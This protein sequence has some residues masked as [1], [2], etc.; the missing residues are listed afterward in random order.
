MESSVRDD[1]RTVDWVEDRAE[2]ITASTTILSSGLA[3]A[4][5]EMSASTP[6]SSVSASPSAPSHA[7]AAEETST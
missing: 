1:G 2:S 4:S 5:P 7:R 6:S 3:N